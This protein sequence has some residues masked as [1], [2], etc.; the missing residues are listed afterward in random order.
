MHHVKDTL[1]TDRKMSEKNV[2]MLEE[3]SCSQTETESAMG[4]ALSDAATC[5]CSSDT[6]KNNFCAESN[7]SQL[8]VLERPIDVN[9]VLETEVGTEADVGGDYVDVNGG[10]Q[11]VGTSGYESGRFSLS[12]SINRK[13]LARK[14][15]RGVVDN[16]HFQK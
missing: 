14:T 15:V 1:F 8:E 13:R 16:S 7:E 2:T 6:P 12:D 10:V 4:A 11:S 5:C 3:I 9:G